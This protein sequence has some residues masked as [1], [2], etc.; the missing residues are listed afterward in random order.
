MASPDIKERVAALST[1]KA[2]GG[3]GLVSDPQ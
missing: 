1:P 2:V 3:E